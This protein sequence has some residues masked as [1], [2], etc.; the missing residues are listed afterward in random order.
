MYKWIINRSFNTG[1]V[2]FL[3]TRSVR[4]QIIKLEL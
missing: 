3:G 2:Y 4:A 1:F